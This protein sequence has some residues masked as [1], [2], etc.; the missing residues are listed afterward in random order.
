MNRKFIDIGLGLK[1][2]QIRRKFLITPKFY[3]DNINNK[4]I[5]EEMLEQ[6]LY[7]VNKRAKNHR[8][9]AREVRQMYRNDWYGTADHEYELSDEMY[10]IKD[11][12][13]KIV[14]PVKA[15][16]TIR[17]TTRRFEYDEFDMDSFKDD[18]HVI[19]YEEYY[20]WSGVRMCEVE[21]EF[22]ECFLLYKIGNHTFHTPVDEDDEYYQSF[23]K[24]GKV[25]ELHDFTTYGA[26]V[27]DLISMQFVKKLVRLIESG[28]Y[29]YI[30]A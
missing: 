4:I 23:I 18:Y 26:D 2:D 22:K 20:N 13:L 21:Y 10:H 30:A 15:H 12:L 5:T 24:S 17:S 8:D 28:N 16:C 7:S 6:C 19:T 3:T 11:L 9:R 27:S 25:E 14:E 29:T 1:I